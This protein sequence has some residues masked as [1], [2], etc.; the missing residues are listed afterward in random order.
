MASLTKDYDNQ[1]LLGQVYTPRFVVEKILSDIGFDND[2]ILGKT[3][4]DPS[5]GD[6]RFLVVVAEKIIDFSPEENLRENL[7]KIYGWDIDNQAIAYCIENLNELIKPF[8]IKVNWN[9]SV[10][11]SLEK[12]Q[13]NTQKFDFIVGNPPYIRIQHL[14]GTE[15]KFIQ[16]AYKFCKSGSTDTYIAFYEL[17]N[18]LLAKNGI[19]A[20]ITPNTFFYSETA[21][22]MRAYFAHKQSIIKITNYGHIQLFDNAITYSAITIFGKE[23]RNEFI[24]EQ[25]ST[26]TT[27]ENRL[28]DFSEIKNQRIWQLSLENTINRTGTKLKDICNIHVGITTLCD[29]GYIFKIKDVEN[30]PDFVWA[31]T[32]LKGLIKLERA[33]LKPIVKASKLKNSTDKISEYILFPYQKVNEKHKII[34]EEKLKNNFPFAYNYLLS[35]KDELDKRDNGKLNT[36]AWYAF[37]RSQ[38]LDTSFGKKILFSPMNNKPN[39]VLFENSACTFYSGYCIKYEGDFEFL[40]SELNSQ[41][42][43]DYMQ[44]SSRDFRG[45]WKAYNKQALEDFTITQTN[46]Q[47]LNKKATSPNMGLAKAGQKCLFELW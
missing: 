10:T 21:K 9:I 15:R 6:G 30:E 12:I 40:L 47:V 20:L 39:F 19:C 38:G 3:I 23:V 25:A 32:K 2:T 8:D 22:V 31:D 18:F 13:D 5:C 34:T 16:R 7:E 26:Q 24:F 36:V 14:A 35:I 33:I 28:I 44:V 29:K 27:F 37:G 45:G 11:N 4:L 42:M 17:C 43:T 46:G 1:K 41:K